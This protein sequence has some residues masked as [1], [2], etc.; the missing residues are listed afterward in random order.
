MFHPLRSREALEAG[1]LKLRDDLT[2]LRR[3]A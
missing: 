3:G 1:V 2:R